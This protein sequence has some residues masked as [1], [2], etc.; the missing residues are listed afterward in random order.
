MRTQQF[1]EGYILPNRKLQFLY[2]MY[3]FSI[4]VHMKLLFFRS[5]SVT[6]SFPFAQKMAR[7]PKSKQNVQT[8]CDQIE[9][10]QCFDMSEMRK[11][12]TTY[13]IMWC[14]I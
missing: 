9:T 2:Y 10:V 7:V 12:L 13:A 14:T 8:K 4:F 11:Y 6:Q 3:F 1:F 5:N